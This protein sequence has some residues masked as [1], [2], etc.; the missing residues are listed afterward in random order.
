MIRRP[1][2]YT[3][4]GTLFPNTALFRSLD[5][6]GL[7][8]SSV[9]DAVSRSNRLIAAGALDTGT[10]RFPIKVPGLY[11]GVEDILDQPIKV[12]GDAVVRI[13]DVAY[14]QRGFKARD[15]YAR[16]DGAPAIAIEVTQ[17]TGANR[18]PPIPHPR[19]TPTPE[20]PCR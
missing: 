2:R 20:R 10:G 13:R 15:G 6:Y 17:R 8:A 11:D 19:R 9:L 7:Q 1:P 3:R 16:L 18:T 14:V 4:T 5:S 12:N